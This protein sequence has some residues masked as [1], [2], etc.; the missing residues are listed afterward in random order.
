VR[1]AQIKAQKSAFT[2]DTDTSIFPDD[3]MMAG[4][5]FYFLKA[6]NLTIPLNWASSCERWL[7]AKL[8][9]NQFLPCRLRQ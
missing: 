2:L 8:K 7:I 6:K 9:I 3:L 1:Q 5:K 4:L